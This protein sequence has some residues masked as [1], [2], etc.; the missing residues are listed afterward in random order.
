MS[1]KAIKNTFYNLKKLI[2]TP[3]ITQLKDIYKGKTALCLSAG[4]SLRENIE[5]IKNNQDKFVIFAVNPTIKLLSANGIKPDFIVNIET[6]NTSIQ[7]QTINPEEYY[8]IMEAFTGKEVYS[9]KTKKTF[10]Y[11]SD[12]N[13]ANPWLN[14]CLDN[15]ENLKTLGTVS[16]TALMSAYLMGFKKIILCGQDLA[17]QDGRCYAQGS[18]YEELECVFDE[19]KNKYVIRA[20]DFDKYAQSFKSD[21]Y[22]DEF[23]KNCANKVIN[24]LNNSLYTVISQDGRKIPTQTGYAIFIDWFKQAAIEMKKERPEIE[25]INSSVGGA[26]IDGFENLPLKDLVDD[27]PVVEKLNLD[28]Y[29]P[30]FNKEKIKLKIELLVKKLTLYKNVVCE[31]IE[32]CEKLLKEITIKKVFTSN[33]LKMIQKQDNLIAELASS[34]K[35]VDLRYIIFFSLC[36]YSDV[37]KDDCFINIEEAQKTINSVIKISKEANDIYEIILKTLADC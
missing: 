23:Y 9:L 37:L 35:D 29:T 31:H 13:F 3:N 34:K 17:Y 30:N 15:K 36:K 12:T 21:N 5:I 20:K 25:L 7:F 24:F 28:N 4:P 16:Y 22:S 19:T 6:T 10:S 27:L 1:P 14:N 26:Q 18:Q 11:V 32:I 2:S 33:I 8:F